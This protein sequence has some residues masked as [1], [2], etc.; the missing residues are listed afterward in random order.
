MGFNATFDVQTAKELKVSGLIGHAI[1][2]GKKSACVGE[3]EIGMGQTSAWRINSITPRTS[4]AIYFEVVTPAGQ[5]LSPG[6]RGLIQFVTHHQHSSGQMRLRVTTIARNFA[7]ANSPSIA[8][9]FDQEAAA[10]LMARIAVFKAEIDDSPDVLRWLD[11]MLIVSARSL[12]IIS[13]EEDVNNSL[14]MIQPTL[15]SYTFDV[16][17]QPVLPF[18]SST[19]SILLFS[20]VKRWPNGGRQVTKIRMGMRT[21]KSCWKTLLQML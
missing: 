10:V 11:R 16:E 12:H 1:S 17:P 5:P 6:S 4:A 9:S 8:S 15:M 19:P 2:I 3:T 18:S 7:E 21:S 13:N 20:T 14:I